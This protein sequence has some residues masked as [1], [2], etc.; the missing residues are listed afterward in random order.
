[1]ELYQKHQDLEPKIIYNQ[2]LDPAF[3]AQVGGFPIGGKAALENGDI[4]RSTI[5]NNTNDPNVSMTGW[6]KTNDAS[7]IISAGGETQQDLNNVY[8]SQLLTTDQF[9]IIIPEV[10]DTGRLQR[11]FDASFDKQQVLNLVGDFN[12]SDTLHARHNFNGSSSK[13]T[14][15]LDY[16]KDALIVGAEKSTA[17]T[18]RLAGKVIQF[19]SIETT[20]TS[21]ANNWG[22]NTGSCA[23]KIINPQ[24]CKMWFGTTMNFE[25][26]VYC[27]AYNTDANY[28]QYNFGRHV[29]HKRPMTFHVDGSVSVASMNQNTLTGGRFA[30]SNTTSRIAGIYL[31][32]F[33]ITGGT[34]SSLNNNLILNPSV[35]GSADEYAMLFESQGTNISGLAYNTIIAPRL[36][37]GSV[38]GKKMA[39]RGDR[40]RWNRVMQGYGVEYDSVVNEN[41]AAVNTIFGSTGAMQFTGSLGNTAVGSFQN[42]SGIAFPTFAV[43]A[44]GKTNLEMM[45]L[46]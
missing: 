5:P 2:I 22:S 33:L 42:N 24:E 1:V 23:I 11:A 29:F 21:G 27:L 8:S 4:V 12:C 43:Y 30:A 38:V 7:Q 36:E 20:K 6:V 14:F 3:T 16:A 39:F 25:F 31:M 40:V 41:G 37:T 13:I 46:G 34:L 44:T 15:P 19:P 28:N 35:E 26:G 32:H 17:T 9:K 18:T 45:R 10:D